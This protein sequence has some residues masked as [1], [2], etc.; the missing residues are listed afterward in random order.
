MNLLKAS[1]PKYPPFRSLCDG[2]RDKYTIPVF[3]VK[4]QPLTY[5]HFFHH[6]TLIGASDPKILSVSLYLQQLTR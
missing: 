4:G 1:D 3:K 6:M 2:Y 5:L